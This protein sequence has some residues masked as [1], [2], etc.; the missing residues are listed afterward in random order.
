M[1]TT[2]T[3]HLA[4]AVLIALFCSQAALAQHT[5]RAVL[6]P[7]AQRKPAPGFHL[8]SNSGQIRDISNYRGRVVLIN[9][10]ATACGGCVLE[11]P[12]IVKIKQTFSGSAF[13]AL[14]V[15]MDL[16][17]EKLSRPAQAW[18]RIRSFSQSHHFNYPIL[19]GNDAIRAAYGLKQL[20]DTFLIDR[21]GRIAAVYVGVVNP[22]DVQ[23]NI[24]RLLSE[25]SSP[26]RR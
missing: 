3:K 2:R 17:F 25:P 24:R 5:V 14:G 4:M 10:W 8:V 18:G 16:W 20:P 1:L 22:E 26:S 7:I 6:I 9:M 21:Q 11:I 23:A 19:L 13:T 15:S 12:S